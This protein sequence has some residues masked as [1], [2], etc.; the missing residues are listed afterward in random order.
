VN[1]TTF[2]NILRQTF[3]F[4]NQVNLFIVYKYSSYIYGIKELEALHLKQLEIPKTRIF[5]SM[6]NR[7]HFE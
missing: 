6:L 5:I 3:V 7:E 4:S 1:I 2:Y